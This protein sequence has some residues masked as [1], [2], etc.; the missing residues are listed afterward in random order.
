MLGERHHD[1]RRDVHP[2]D[3][4]V[5][6]DPQESLELEPW[7]GDDRGPRVK[8]QVHDHRHPIDV[9]EGHHPQHTLAF[10][11]VE[12][13]LGLG[14]VRHQVAVRQHD[15]LGHAGR[16]A[17][18]GKCHQVFGWIDLDREVIDRLRQ[19]V[20]ERGRT[21]GGAEDK[22]FFDGRVLDRFTGPIHER[23]NGQ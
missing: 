6:E 11:H 19:E 21:I 10:A 7:H 20:A 23:R 12:A 17:R 22:Y 1:R 4:I 5:L 9:V 3:A 16:A 2:G 8:G 14:D 15:T 18:I 13:L